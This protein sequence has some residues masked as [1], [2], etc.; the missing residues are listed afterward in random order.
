VDLRNTGGD[1]V[2][3]IILR[4]VVISLI[5]GIVLSALGITPSNLFSSLNVLARRIYDLGFGAIDWVLQYLIVGAMVV[6][7][8]YLV[9]R[10][11]GGV[12][13]RRD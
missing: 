8:I 4:L 5:V 1:S 6:V 10:V 12:R 9:A 3:G 7:P 13:S 2:A 11:L